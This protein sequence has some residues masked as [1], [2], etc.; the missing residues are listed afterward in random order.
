MLVNKSESLFMG[1][2]GS[3]GSGTSP[4]TLPRIGDGPQF[5][6]TFSAGR[7]R[8]GATRRR[9]WG[10]RGPGR[11]ARGLPGALDDPGGGGGAGGRLE[12]DVR[13]RLPRKAADEAPELAR[14]Q[15][16]RGAGAAARA[17]AFPL[18]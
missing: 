14:R 16:R 6:W 11:V 1:P 15:V 9:R 17:A 18:A 3:G 12:R 4:A 10:S 5:D 8:R 2:P 13:V 7:P